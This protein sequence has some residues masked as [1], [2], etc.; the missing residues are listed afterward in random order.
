MAR[1]GHGSVRRSWQTTIPVRRRP[2]LG[3]DTAEPVT[4]YACNIDGANSG[5][6][7][8]DSLSTLCLRP[9]ISFHEL[10]TSGGTFV[11][12]LVSV[13]HFYFLHHFL[14]L[15]HDQFGRLLVFFF[16]LFTV[17][18]SSYSPPFLMFLIFWALT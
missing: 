6:I 15:L 17:S 9:I 13:N 3:T 14:Q 8:G 10:E 5:L 18:L 11:N 7:S 1:L 16:S 4:T 12:R 2:C